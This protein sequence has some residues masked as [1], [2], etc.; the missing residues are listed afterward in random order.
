MLSGKPDLHFGPGSTSGFTPAGI[1]AFDDLRPAAVVR[2]LIQ[3]SLDAARLA[4]TSP[5]IVRFRLSEAE[6][7]R[8][9]GIENYKYAFR[10][11]VETQK[12]LAGGQLARQAE[13][14]KNRIATTFPEDRV[15]FLSI[16]DNGIGLDE[17]KMT[18]LLSDGVSVKGKGA[19]GTY[20]NGHSTA[21]P[22]SNLRYVLYGGITENGKRIASGHAVLASHN[23]EGNK[24]SQGADGYFIRGFNAGTGTGKLYD[25]ATG[26]EIPKLIRTELNR[27]R[28]D[29]GH[30]SVVIIT[31]FNNFMEESKELWDMV[32]LSASANFFVAIAEGELEVHV[33]D[34]RKSKN[35]KDWKLDQDNLLST[36]ESHRDNK[37][38]KNFISGL[39]AFEAYK[40]YCRKP[41]NPM[42]TR[43]GV[44][45][46]RIAE[47]PSGVT[48]IDL[49]RNG[50][51]ITNELPSFQGK[52]AD[53]IPFHA[54]LSLKSEDGGRLHDLVRTAENPLHDTLVPKNL[55]RRDQPDFYDALR[56]IIKWLKENTK[57]LNSEAF[58]S[59]DFLALEYGI[60]GLAGS[61]GAKALRGSPVVITGRPA[62]R[63]ETILDHP[64]SEPADPNS[65]F[66]PKPRSSLKRGRTRPSLP[67]LVQA[68]S[69]VIAN[70]RRRIHIEFANEC[71]DAQIRLM[72]DEGLDATCDRHGLDPYN[73][74]EIGDVTINGTS[75][76]DNCLAHQN[77]RPVG[78]RLGNVSK[79]EKITIE[80]NIRINGVFSNIDEPSLRIEVFKTPGEA[81]KTRQKEEHE[82]TSKG[83]S[84]LSSASGAEENA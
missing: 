68:T 52:F 74:T 6:L 13:L 16:L 38:S 60:G 51:W 72:V 44:I 24:H 3:N 78:V 53:R 50:M 61:G 76:S 64:N 8:I 29:S 43:Q 66:E 71:E 11:A 58:S 56:E 37:R 41:T 49:C 30:G 79:G 63:F 36:L 4:K 45:D 75:I 19:T 80:A 77:G 31:A 27:I 81:P 20:G 40:T 9:P 83:Q 2:E 84:D 10:K 65:D 23:M 54:V 25:F 67:A 32:S 33:E 70:E 69:R 35:S 28:K 14:V 48:R 59:D 39:K 15:E 22:A 26:N 55:D 17:K 1:A 12:Q 34:I 62:R 21:I 73:P 7:S 42:A 47:N 18:A 5:A 57:A 46:I 82:S